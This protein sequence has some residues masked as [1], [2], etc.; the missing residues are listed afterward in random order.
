MKASKRCGSSLSASILA[1]SGVEAIANLTGVMKLDPGSTPEHPKVTRTA[2]KA[3]VPVALEVV[4][5]TALLGWAMLSLPSI[6]NK[7][8]GLTSRSEIVAALTK[9]HE[10]MLRFIAEQF[11]AASFGFGLA[12]RSAGSWASFFCC[13]S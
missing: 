1:L 12:R 13:S 6:L 3:I 10:D 4:F 7:T 5:G 11:G 9:R 8:L 2:T